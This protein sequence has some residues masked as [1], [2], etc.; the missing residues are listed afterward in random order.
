MKV[1]CRIFGRLVV[2][3]GCAALTAVSAP[4]FEGDAVAPPPTA[5]DRCVLEELQKHG[6]A[7]APPCSDAVFL[8]RVYLDTT[9]VL[10]EP[11][12][13][14]AFLADD[15]TEKRTKVIDELLDSR[16]FAEYRT[17]KWCDILRV[18]AE[19]PI[20]LWPNGV[21]AYERWIRHAL[22]IN[23]PYDRFARDL[24][25]SS[26]SNFRTPA[27]NFYRAVQGEE[28]AALAEAAALTFMGTR[29]ENWPEARRK[30]FEAFFSRVGFKGT[31]EWKEVIVHLD[32]APAGPVHA[33]FPEGATVTIPYGSDP[34]QVFADWLIQPENPWFARNLVNR[35]WSRLMGRGIIHE[36]DDIRPDNP[37]T[38]PALL[39]C[40]ENEFVESGYDLRRLYRLILVSRTYQQSS[41]PRGD[42]AEAERLFACYPVRRLE[43]EVLIDALVQITGA[44]ESYSSPIP[45]PFTFV[46][47]TQRSVLLADGSITS[48]FLEMFGRPSRDTGREHERNNR[49]TAK[50]R[51]H[52][53]NS[54]HIQKKITQA[55]RLWVGLESKRGSPVEAL[56]HLYLTILS[57]RPTPR[58]RRAVADYFV[59]AEGGRRA[60]AIDLVWALINS[61]EFQYRH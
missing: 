10:P 22:R 60:A 30:G 47:E 26:G 20:N 9:G 58:E 61:K 19:Y 56:N 48:P 2:G 34:R 16:E 29:V 35:V 8:R 37:P 18:K 14:R 13:I 59:N 41:I 55:R 28:P 32:P 50:Q 12:R 24:L 44:G 54:T 40:L 6:V 1:S 52:M 7:P 57:R 5:L 4:P 3:L 42:A 39:A 53:L 23:L 49:P 21:Q 31:A 38:H 11:K 36:P 15:S 51:L 25:T 27:V 45:E 17:L 33:V 43:A 46:P